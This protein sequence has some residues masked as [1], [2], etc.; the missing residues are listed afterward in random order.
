[1]ETQKPIEK[2]LTGA[3]VEMRWYRGVIVNGTKVKA[4]V[5]SRMFDETLC[6]MVMSP[7]SKCII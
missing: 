6:D 3:T 2:V 7:L 4:W 5:K 1:M